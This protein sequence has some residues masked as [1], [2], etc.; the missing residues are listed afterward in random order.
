[1]GGGSQPPFAAMPAQKLPLRR[2]LSS[3]FTSSS[4][5]S[6]CAA[7]LLN[8]PQCLPNKFRARSAR[9]AHC[10]LGPRASAEH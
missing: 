8:I 7:T 10:R 1:M 6:L 9:P 3:V 2:T 5:T 4:S